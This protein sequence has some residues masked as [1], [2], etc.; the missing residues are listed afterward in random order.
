MITKVSDVKPLIAEGKQDPRAVWPR[1]RALAEDADWRAREVAAT[2]MVEIAKKKPDA[3][4]AEMLKWAKDKDENV[5]RAASEGLRGLARVD[6]ALVLPVL[7]RLRAD[8][9]V[10]VRKSVSNLMR[11]GSKKQPEL[12]LDVAKKWARDRDENTDWILQHGL[13]K[14]RDTHAAEVRAIVGERAGKKA[15]SKRG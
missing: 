11:D 5:R 6:F 2:A 7:E 13:E 8:P 9:S 15:P 10:Y 4:V 14:L 1:L 3:V 12:V